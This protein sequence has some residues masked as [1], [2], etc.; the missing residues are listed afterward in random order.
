MDIDNIKTKK[1]KKQFDLINFFS[2]NIKNII[3]ILLLIG[4]I[5]VLKSPYE[6][7]NKIGNFFN[8]VY[9]GFT[10]GIRGNN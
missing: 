9:E 5:F 10:T 1:I 2:S 4:F 6:T 7:S 3:F 8:Q